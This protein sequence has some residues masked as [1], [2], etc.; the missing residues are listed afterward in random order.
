M[1]GSPRLLIPGIVVLAFGATLQARAT[2]AVKTVKI[3][4]PR[5]RLWP[6]GRPQPLCHLVKDLRTREA[7][8]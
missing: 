8:A 2:G 4:G 5:L 7:Q 3:W 1:L 6:A